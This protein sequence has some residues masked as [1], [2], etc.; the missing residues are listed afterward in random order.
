ML[1]TETG[2]AKREAPDDR[3]GQDGEDVEHA[4]AEH[5]HVRLEERDHGRDERRRRPRW[6]ARR[7]PVVPEPLAAHRRNGTGGPRQLCPELDGA[8]RAR[9]H[10]DRRRRLRRL[11]RRAPA[12]PARRDDRQPGEL[13]A[14]HAAAPGGGVRDARA[15]PRRRAAADDVPAR[16]A[17]RRPGDRPRRRRA[18]SAHGGRQST[19]RSRSATSGSSSHSA[20]SRACCRFPASPSTD[21]ASATSPT[22][23]RSATTCSGSSRPRTRRATPEDAA[24]HLA[25]VFVGAGYAG[26]EALAEL[27]DLVRDALRYYPGLADGT[28]ALG[29]RRRGAEDPPGD[30]HP[31][32]R[33]RGSAARAARRG[34]PR[35][36]A[37]RVGRRRGASALGRHAGRDRH[38]RLDRRASAPTR[39]LAELGVPLDDRGRVARRRAPPRVRASTA[40]G[41]SATAPP[42]RILATP[43]GP[44][45]RPRSTPSARP[46]AWHG[47]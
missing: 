15:A 44:T 41:R 12:R 22:R 2:S 10:S 38:A 43:G 11:D 16:R 42:S 23:S 8:T 33:V 37:P 29:A 28:A 25:F 21:T 14:V 30:P 27:A 18:R 45:R 35:L 19:A 39:G 13:H 31:A 24:R 40:S 34:D 17:R 7:D 26:V 1:A 36:D 3:H 6:P 5:R 20:R 4:E 9:R 46:G 47:T 32:R